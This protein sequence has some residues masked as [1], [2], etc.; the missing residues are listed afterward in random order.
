[1]SRISLQEFTPR[2]MN[3]RSLLLNEDY[4]VRHSEQHYGLVVEMVE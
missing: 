4:K 2:L 3:N 1:M